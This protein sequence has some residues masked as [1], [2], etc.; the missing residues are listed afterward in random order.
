MTSEPLTRNDVEELIDVELE[1]VEGRTVA[2][3]MEQIDYRFGDLLR[4]IGEL[5][6]RVNTLENEGRCNHE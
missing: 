1:G 2:Y 4:L 3:V 6:S 5:S